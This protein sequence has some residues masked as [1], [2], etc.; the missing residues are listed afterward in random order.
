MLLLGLFYV[1]TVCVMTTESEPLKEINLT[2]EQTE[3]FWKKIKRLNPSECWVWTASTRDGYG[4]FNVNGKMVASHRI[5]WVLAN[6]QIPH[7]N[8]PHGICICHRCDVR[9]CCNP[10][11]MFLGTNAVNIHDMISKGRHVARRG[12][13]SGMSKLTTE[14]VYKIRHMH[15]SG[16]TYFRDIAT[17]FG[18]SEQLIGMIVRRKIWKHLPATPPASSNNVQ[19]TQRP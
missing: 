4:Q 18:V 13:L 9:A 11:H 1:I 3:R 16:S 19:E 10:S 14:Q 15:A 7:D 8:S 12:D 2:H 5:A 6:G 17:K